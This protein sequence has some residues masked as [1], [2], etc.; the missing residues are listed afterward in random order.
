MAGP[1]HTLWSPWPPLVIRSYSHYKPKIDLELEC[2]AA[3]KMATP[4]T[5]DRL[6]KEYHG[7]QGKGTEGGKPR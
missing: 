1:C 3:L 5:A 7:V 6:V 4:R 2:I